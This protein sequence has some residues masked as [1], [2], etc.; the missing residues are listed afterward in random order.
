MTGRTS[1]ER[2]ARTMWSQQV[3]KKTK[4]PTSVLAIRAS[5]SLMRSDKIVFRSL[6]FKMATG[7]ESQSAAFVDGGQESGSSTLKHHWNSAVLELFVILVIFNY[8][9]F[10]GLKYT[11]S[12]TIIFSI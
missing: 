1:S 2:Q 8:L 7:K 6:A 12:L 9:A 11:F 5:R 10:L 4:L 3:R